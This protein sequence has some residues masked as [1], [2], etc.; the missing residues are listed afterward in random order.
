MNMNNGRLIRRVHLFGVVLLSVVVV[1]VRPADAQDDRLYAGASAMLSTQEP[2][3]PLQGSSQ[4]TPGV[5]GTALGV[6]GE[7]G[8]FFTRMVS[9]AFEASAPGRFKYVQFTG[10]PNSRIEGRYR[11]LV[12]SG[13]FHAHVPPIGPVRLA[14]I[15]GPSVI[16]EETRLRQAFAPFGSSNFGPF[17]REQSLTNWTLGATFGADVAVQVGRHV[18]I[19][20]QIR[21]HWIQ[22]EAIGSGLSSLVTRPG[23]G[24]RA[25]F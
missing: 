19:V 18:Q 16:R 8:A 2:G 6:S 1:G 17:E 4:A 5:G 22:R 23:V 7:F 9:L 3:V 25:V 21:W 20:P 15:A 10:I 24:V 13:L 11:D 14:A 12:F